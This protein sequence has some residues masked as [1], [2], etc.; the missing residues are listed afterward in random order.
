MTQTPDFDAIIAAMLPFLGLE[1]PESELAQVR[2]HLGIAAGHAAKLLAS[3]I[4]DHAEPAPVF[5]P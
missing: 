2:V 4:E 5:T 1:V 3:P